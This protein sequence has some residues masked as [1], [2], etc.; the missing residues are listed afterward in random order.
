MG[1]ERRSGASGS[2]P[3]GTWWIHHVHF[4]SRSSPR[5]RKLGYARAVDGHGEGLTNEEVAEVVGKSLATVKRYIKDAREAM[6]AQ[7]ASMAPEEVAG[8]YR[9]G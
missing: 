3:G 6:Q 4:R 9:S 8:T 1:A 5:C 2:Q 7:I